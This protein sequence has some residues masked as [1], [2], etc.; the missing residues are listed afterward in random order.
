ME[1]GQ[2]GGKMEVQMGTQRSE[3]EKDLCTER[4]REEGRGPLLPNGLTLTLHLQFFQIYTKGE[5]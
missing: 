2:L 5:G 3:A 4:H 1:P